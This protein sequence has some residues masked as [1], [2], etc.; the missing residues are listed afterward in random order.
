MNRAFL[1]L[2]LSMTTFSV[3]GG[4]IEI[5]CPKIG[6][7]PPYDINWRTTDGWQQVTSAQSY[8][9][10]RNYIDPQG[11]LRCSYKAAAHSTVNVFDLKKLPPENVNCQKKN[12]VCGFKCTTQ[13]KRIAP[14]I[15]RP[16]HLI[17][18]Q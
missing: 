1:G 14:Q 7:T 10:C 15:N 11:N 5:D 4:I 2:A 6:V 12:V 9:N 3:S 18:P 13:V 8:L 17:K 16:L